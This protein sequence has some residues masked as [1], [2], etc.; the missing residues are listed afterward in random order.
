VDAPDLLLGFSEVGAAFVGFSSIVAIFGRRPDGAWAPMDRIRIRNLVEQALSVAIFGFLPL[1]L[2]RLNA[3]DTITW[4]I[5]SVVLGAFLSVDLALW[6]IRARVLHKHAS[7]RKWMAALGGTSLGAALL[8]QVF[9]VSGWIFDNE[10]GP[11]VAGLLLILFLAGLQ[12]A[13]LVFSHLGS[14]K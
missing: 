4:T 2:F 9:N 5:S 1:V 13:L 6:I 11:Y 14:T 10:S 3:S 7:L 8:L 12:F